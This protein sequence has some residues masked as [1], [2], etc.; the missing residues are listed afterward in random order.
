[1]NFGGFILMKIGIDKKEVLVIL[2]YPLSTHKNVDILNKERDMLKKSLE[3]LLW[4]VIAGAITSQTYLVIVH[5]I[6]D[7]VVSAF[8]AALVPIF[9]VVLAFLFVMGTEF[10]D[11]IPARVYT[12][13]AVAAT[14]FGIAATGALIA[15]AFF[16]HVIAGIVITLFC[17][18]IGVALILPSFGNN[19]HT[20]CASFCDDD[21]SPLPISP[22]AA[23]AAAACLVNT[24]FPNTR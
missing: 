7:P 13:V 6:R 17:L 10:N 3:W 4:L 23:G 15:M 11:S 18:I 9:L 8:L 14:C 16:G 19:N 1:M 21:I 20:S 24:V 12:R 5:T 22:I 2:F